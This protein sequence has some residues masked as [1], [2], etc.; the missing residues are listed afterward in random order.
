MFSLICTRINGWVN[1]GEAGDL[2]PHRSHYDVI[3]MFMGHDLHMK[4]YHWTTTKGQVTTTVFETTQN[5]RS[6]VSALYWRH[7]GHDSVSNHQPYDCLLNCLFRRTSKI[8][9]KLRVTGL[10]VG[11][12]P[13]TGEFPAQRASN[14]ENDPIWWRHH[15]DTAVSPSI[16]VRQNVFWQFSNVHFLWYFIIHLW[17]EVTP[18]LCTK[19]PRY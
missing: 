13:E 8:I 5:T 6:T 2:R 3:V 14:A 19:R 16:L 17:Q 18:K 10:C 12:S 4:W 11:N 7:N 1:N 15:G 9:S